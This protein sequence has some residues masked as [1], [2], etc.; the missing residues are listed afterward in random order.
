Y[1]PSYRR[2]GALYDSAESFPQPRCHPETRTEMLDALYSWAIGSDPAPSIFWLHGPAGAGK[3]AIMQ[4]LCRRLTDSGR[5]G[6]SF[7]FK[8]GHTT[9]GNARVLFTTLAYQLALQNSFLK[10]PISECVQD[11]PSFTTGSMEKQFQRLIVRPCQSPL[12]PHH[13]SIFLIDGL[14]EC[15]GENVQQEVLRFVS[16]AVRE[17]IRMFRI[18]IASR[19]EPH[20]REIFERSSVKPLYRGLNITQSLNDV[21]K[22]FRDEFWRIHR[23]HRVTME[24]I[25][26]PW[27]SWNV[28]N[29]LVE[30]SSGYFIYASTV[31]KFV[32]DKDFRPTERLSMVIDWQNIPTDSDRP[33]E[34]LDQLYTQILLMARTR[35]RLVR[36]LCAQDNFPELSSGEI[37]QL[38]QLN[39]GDFGLSLRRLHSVFHIPL[40]GSPISAYHASFQD[41]LRD[42]NRSGEFCVATLERRKELAHTV[43]TALSNMFDNSSGGRFSSSSEHVAWY[44][45]FHGANV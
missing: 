41:F 38:L 1:P 10:G 30:K 45:Y 39:A 29:G 7:F 22:T 36:I 5:L 18:L 28:L 24:A 21:K 25:P 19:P 27:P 6:G 35:S 37:E 42:P 8:R 23:E 12:N 17:N 40:D 16:D 33:F 15:E 2:I 34:A 31:I 26:T 44:V 32:D 9:C 4:T 11:D 14:D 3:S 20:I 43:L 13:E